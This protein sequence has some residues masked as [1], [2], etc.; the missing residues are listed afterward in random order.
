MYECFHHFLNLIFI[1]LY[2]AERGGCFR[3]FCLKIQT[4]SW[5]V[6]YKT[7][8]FMNV[9]NDWMK[10]NEC[11]GEC[12]CICSSNDEMTSSSFPTWKMYDYLRIVFVYSAIWCDWFCVITHS[13]LKLNHDN[14]IIQSTRP[15]HPLNFIN[16]MAEW[17]K[18][19][20]R[21][22]LCP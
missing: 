16:E 17:K 8:K 11:S 14:T 12:K 10:W 6:L 13:E 7:Q 22:L 2:I 4:T 18:K 15:I 5:N 1:I 9:L 20:L 21:L 3:S 19:L